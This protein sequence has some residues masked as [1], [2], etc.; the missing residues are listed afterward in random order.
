MAN[1]KFDLTDE[2]TKA[3]VTGWEDGQDYTITMT[4]SAAGLATYEEA[5]PEEETEAEGGIA[6]APGPAAVKA[7]M[8]G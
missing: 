4:N 8:A 1:L 2:E 6:T 7:A 5:A 3:T